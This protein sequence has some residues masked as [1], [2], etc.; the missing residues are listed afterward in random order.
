MRYHRGY[1]ER[2]WKFLYSLDAFLFVVAI[3]Y[4]LS[5]VIEA[6]FVLTPQQKLILG[7]FNLFVLG[8]SLLELLT[9][10]ALSSSKSYFF[11]DEYWD[12]VFTSLL[13]LVTLYVVY[14]HFFEKGLPF[15][16]ALLITPHELHL[17]LFR[18]VLLINVL[19][20]FK[21]FNKIILG[22]KITPSQLLVGGFFLIIILGSLLLSLPHAATQKTSFIDALFTSTS[23]TCVTGLITLQTGTHFSWLGQWILMGLM[24][25][26][27]LGIMT[28]SAFMALLLMGRLGIE[29][30]KIMTEAV[31]IKGQHQLYFLLKEI[32]VFTFIME[33]IGTAVFTWR[34]YPLFNNFSK[35]L[36][37]GLFHSISGFNNA[38]F[39][40]FADS[41]I[42]FQKD[43]Y[44]LITMSLL[45]ILGGIGFLVIAD[46][47]N[48]VTADKK[49]H[50]LRHLSPQTKL[51][52]GLTTAL[53]LGGTALI[54]FTENSGEF[55]KLPLPYQI[56][57]AF[58]MAVTPR[59]AGFNAVDIGLLSPATLLTVMMLMVIGGGSGSTAGGIKVNT[60]GVLMALLKTTVLARSKAVIFERTIPIFTIHKAI[61]V[62]FFA[63]SLTTFGT[64]FILMHDN[65]PFIQTLFEIISA[66][67]TVG[68]SMG[69]T[70]QLSDFGK[71]VIIIMMY[72]GRIG[73][74][75][76]VVALAKKEKE[77]VRIDYPEEN[78]VVG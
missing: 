63:A 75:A 17:L 29:G 54:F 26:G 47:L 49:S 69:I 53:I 18:T 13:S 55:S 73:P 36:Y 19:I 43:P 48:Y 66:F 31:E 10:F 5:L 39:S 11:S 23:A 50:R 41:L 67:N 3:F 71:V 40:L 14:V 74:I 32:I 33:A 77:E 70:S 8:I 6:G 1:L 34:F 30:R 35:A 72:L 20:Q 59:T 65:F 52:L 68:L 7:Y 38:G 61:A 27:G 56:L 42:G 57:N 64:L 58:F 2:Y 76:F 9:K 28:L 16:P 44:I 15:H 12:V 4:I 45:I 46:L 78:I 60:L 22:L 24:Q 37:F 51:V 21:E 25:I 62:T